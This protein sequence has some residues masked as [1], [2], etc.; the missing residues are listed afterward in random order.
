VLSA[1]EITERL[2]EAFARFLSIYSE[3]GAHHFHGW[4]HAD[5]SRNYHGPHALVG[6]RL[7]AS[8]RMG[9]RAPVPGHGPPRGPSRE[10][11]FPDH[12]SKVDRRQFVDVVVSDLEDFVEDDTS[13]QRFL[14]HRHMLFVEA[15]YLPAGCSKTWRHDHIRKIDA[16]IRDAERLSATRGSGPLRRR[17]GVRRRR[18][19]AVRGECPVGRV[20]GRRYPARRQPGG[21]APKGHARLIL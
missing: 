6:G 20:A 13:Q 11:D 8:P 14:A 21:A 12:D 1:P 17:R 18:R 15:K 10:L 7:R 4:D 9:A 19:R 16:V 5:D 3:P 2:E